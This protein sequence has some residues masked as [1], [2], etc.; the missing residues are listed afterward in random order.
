[1]LA[2]D[3]VAV[4]WEAPPF[5]PMRLMVA[6]V[7]GDMLSIGSVSLAMT[8]TDVPISPSLI[9]RASFAARHKCAQKVCSLAFRW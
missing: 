2:P 5:T 4:P 1:M 7:K 8:L 6:L 9:L 3:T